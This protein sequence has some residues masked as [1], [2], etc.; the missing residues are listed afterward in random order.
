[1]L[2]HF[3]CV[4]LFATHG[5]WP[6]RLLCPWDSPD[7]NTGVGGHALLQG[8]FPT[9]GRTPDSYVCCTGQVNSLPLAPTGK[10]FYIYIQIICKYKCA[11][12]KGRH[13]HLFCKETFF[14]VFIEFVT[15]L[16]LLCMF[17]FFYVWGRQAHEILAL[18]PSIKPIPTE[19]EDKVL[20]TGPQGKSHYHFKIRITKNFTN[21]FLRKFPRITN[22]NS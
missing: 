20:T 13:H 22:S 16:L 17:C 10:K 12:C 7:K 19:L 5:L 3:S 8:I 2:S 18:Q 11:K 1:M 4:W 14:K 6:A 15:I 21:H 9:Q